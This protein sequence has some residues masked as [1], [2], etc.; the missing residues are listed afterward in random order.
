MPEFKLHN[1]WPT[2]SVLESMHS[3]NISLWWHTADAEQNWHFLPHM[4]QL[5]ST[6]H[7]K[8]LFFAETALTAMIIM[9]FTQ[10]SLT[11]KRMCNLWQNILCILMVKSEKENIFS[12][13]QFCDYYSMSEQ[14]PWDNTHIHTV[15]AQTH[16][17]T[18][19]ICILS[20]WLRMKTINMVKDKIRLDWQS[21]SI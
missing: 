21:H 3:R 13:C 10:L 4:V 2:V 6:K 12:V 7:R 20:E 8:E 17:Q 11:C 14:A 15:H 9:L 19:S 18:K 5:P 16:T 1:W